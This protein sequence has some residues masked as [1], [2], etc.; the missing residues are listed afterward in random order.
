MALKDLSFIMV[1]LF[2]FSLSLHNFAPVYPTTAI[3][4]LNIPY[5]MVIHM[6]YKITLF[7]QCITR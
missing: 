6:I 5:A 1:L 3:Q 7:Q 2:T 4:Q